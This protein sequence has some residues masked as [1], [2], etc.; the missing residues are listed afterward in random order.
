MTLFTTDRDAAELN[1]AL[2]VAMDDLRDGST[3]SPAIT[4]V[5]LAVE[6]LTVAMALGLRSVV[7][8]PDDDMDLAGFAYSAQEGAVSSKRFGILLEHVE[9]EALLAAGLDA[10]DVLSSGVPVTGS[11][12][13]SASSSLMRGSV[14][15]SRKY[16]LRRGQAYRLYVI[17]TSPD[18]LTFVSVTAMFELR[19]R[20]Q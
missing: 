2:E 3:P 17:L 19:P 1:A 11:V 8:T 5:S 4:S 9:D 16:S 15:P 7:F 12:S 10:K 18:P 20:R 14:I 6:G 13:T